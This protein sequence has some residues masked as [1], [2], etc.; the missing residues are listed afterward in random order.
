MSRKILIWLRNFFG[1][2]R[3]E[4]N[5]FIFVVI[6]STAML[7]IPKLTQ[8]QLINSN[9]SQQSG[10][11]QALLDELLLQLNANMKLQSSPKKEEQFKNFDLNLSSSKELER[12][13]F[14]NFLAERIV[15][16]RKQV[17]AFNHK[18]E[19]L[20]IYGLDSAFYQKIYPYI[21]VTTLEKTTSQQPETEHSWQPPKSPIVKKKSL[22]LHALDINQADSSELQK[23][24]G[25]GA[26]FSKRI[27]AYRNLLGGYSSL[28]Q[29]NEV[30]GL[31]GSSLDSLRKYIRINDKYDVNQ[32]KINRVNV[33]SLSNH[34]YISYKQAKIIHNYRQQH[35]NYH[36]AEDLLKIKVLDS[37][38]LNKINPY[39]SFED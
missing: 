6:L 18:S 13:G 15:K 1:F 37:T 2:S 21:R 29:L 23:I 5:G 7:F 19:L 27:I 16:Y 10:S 17:K 35:G 14:P 3:A 33:D 28:N 24:Y 36:N 8:L 26:A 9:K 30:Y 32:I 25:I 22:A 4:S 12:A 38:W 11:E 31:E 34:P 39:L 20:K